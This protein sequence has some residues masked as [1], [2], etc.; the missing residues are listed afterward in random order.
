VKTAYLVKVR[1][2]DTTELGRFLREKV[3]VIE[4]VQSTRITIVLETIEENARLLL[5]SFSS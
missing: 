5:P 1:V 3:G 4:A 2:A